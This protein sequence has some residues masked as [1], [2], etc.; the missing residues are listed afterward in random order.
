MQTFSTPGEVVCSTQLTFTPWPPK[1]PTV[2]QSMLNTGKPEGVAKHN[3]TYSCLNR[4]TLFLKYSRAKAVRYVCIFTDFHPT[5][6]SC[7]VVHFRRQA[8]WPCHGLCC[9]G[10]FRTHVLLIKVMRSHPFRGR[11]TTI[12]PKAQLDVGPL[13]SA[14]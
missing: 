7:C 1:H 12:C 8:S 6:V 11:L 3:H 5:P 2:S 4:P 13:V 10:S 9:Q 14:W